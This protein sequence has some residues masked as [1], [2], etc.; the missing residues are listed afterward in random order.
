[1]DKKEIVSFLRTWAYAYIFT[2]PFTSHKSPLMG[3]LSSLTCLG[4]LHL[5]DDNKDEK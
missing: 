1:M 4:F 3:G 2:A 5:T